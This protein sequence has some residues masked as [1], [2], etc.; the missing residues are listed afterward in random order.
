L[1]L[2]ILG[3]GKEGLSSAQSKKKK[4][5]K[6]FADFVRRGGL[7]SEIKIPSLKKQRGACKSKNPV[8]DIRMAKEKEITM[9]GAKKPRQSVV[10]AVGAGKGGG[11]KN[12]KNQKEPPKRVGPSPLRKRDRRKR[13]GKEGTQGRLLKKKKAGPRVCRNMTTPKREESK[14]GGERKNRET[15]IVSSPEAE[16]MVPFASAN[17][18]GTKRGKGKCD[19]EKK[20]KKEGGKERIWREA[21]RGQPTHRCAGEKR[22]PTILEE[23]ARGRPRR[24]IRLL[25]KKRV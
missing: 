8:G 3:R 12:N 15:V 11:H 22:G 9:R 2:P 17:I 16:T 10:T 19:I 24:K 18:R 21:I 25:R 13:V 1:S 14:Y 6:R 4:G 23:R 20:K 5:K 7:Q